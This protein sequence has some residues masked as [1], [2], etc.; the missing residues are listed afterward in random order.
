MIRRISGVPLLYSGTS[1]ARWFR[2]AATIVGEW[3]LSVYARHWHASRLVPVPVP[4]VA[5]RT[6]K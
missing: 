4:V 5:D 6:R 3:G 1:P 2:T